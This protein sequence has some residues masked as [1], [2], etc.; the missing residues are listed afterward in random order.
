[1]TYLKEQG[2]R[3]DVTEVRF[4]EGLRQRTTPDRQRH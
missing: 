4:G 3:A 2:L 1:M